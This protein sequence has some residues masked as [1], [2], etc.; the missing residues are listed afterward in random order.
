MSETLVTQPL[1]DARG[2]ITLNVLLFDDYE[3]LDVYG[4]MELLAGSNVLP[5]GESKG[6]MKITFISVSG[7]IFGTILKVCAKCQLQ[8]KGEHLDTIWVV[9][10]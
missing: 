4:P 2:F 10:F 5:I 3:L 6:K 9:L 1:D 8:K 7:L